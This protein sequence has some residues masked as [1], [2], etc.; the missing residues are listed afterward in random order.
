MIGTVFVIVA[1]FTS[2][3]FTQ[4]YS[5]NITAW[6]YN[7]S[8]EVDGEK[9]YL[10][11]EP[12]IYNNEVYMPLQELADLL[13]MNLNYDPNERV[14]KIDSNR[15]NVT[16]PNA[17]VVPIAF[18]KNYELETLQRRIKEL[19]QE[20]TMLKAGKL[21][22]QKI[23]TLAEMETYLKNNFKTLEGIPMTLRLRLVGTNQ[24]RLEAYFNSQ[25]LTQWNNLNRRDI[26][27]W[28][29]DAFYAIRDLFNSK[30]V[31]QGDIRIGSYSNSQYAS[32]WT[33]GDRLFYEFRQ[34]DHK[35][36]LYVDGTKI[37]QALNQRLK[38]YNNATF[39][40]EVFVN[41]YDV[42]IVASFDKN[43]KGWSPQLKMQYLKRLK[44]EVERVYSTVNVNGRIV[45]A[46]KTESTLRFSFEGDTIRS[47]DLMNEI[48]TYLNKNYKNFNYGGTT[49]AFTY[50]VSEGY[51]G[52]FTIDLEG[53]FANTD[54]AWI[55]VKDN[56]E[57]SFR[58]Y[59]QT[60]YRYVEGLWN[61]DIFGQ[62][63]DK[64]LQPVTST[65]FYRPG[66]YGSRYL[67]E[68][69]FQ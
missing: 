50:R 5:R 59:I 49:F 37:E 17:S 40:Y 29:D 4:T 23:S 41:Q 58:S 65:E 56:G 2:S 42:D 46:G 15:L 13:Y 57:Y 9:L 44:T 36:N 35:K 19:E 24:Y 11:N 18:Q 26:E 27:A 51:S 63:V 10:E 8:V 47:F 60:S 61:V 32:Y 7:L 53:N 45:E 62:V 54:N 3:S 1:L 16:D 31:I 14:I 52:A 68:L 43:V 21:P 34:A 30:A 66:D 12:F 28:V 20:I 67:Q 38:Y 48:E 64:N 39:T 69:M 25:H 33:K 6:F 22:Y 55:R